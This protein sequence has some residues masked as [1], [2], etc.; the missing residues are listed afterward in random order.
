MIELVFKLLLIS[1][2]EQ[3]CDNLKLLAECFVSLPVL[4]A[5]C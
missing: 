2:A 5:R 3:T 1:F 4:I